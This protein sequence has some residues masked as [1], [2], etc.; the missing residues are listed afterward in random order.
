MEKMSNI[1]TFGNLQVQVVGGRTCKG[2]GEHV[3]IVEST[4]N[5][6]TERVSECLNCE[7]L[8]IKKEHEDFIERVNE[9][10]HVLFFEKYSFVPDDLKQSSF[11]SFDSESPSQKEAYDKCYWYARHFEDD[12]D[13]DSL[14][15]KG[16]YGIGKSHLS[17][18]VADM[19]KAQG[20]N[21]I[22]IDMPTLSKKIR[23]S[24]NGSGIT[25]DEIL[26]AIDKADLVI[27]DDMGAERVKKDEKGDSW[28]GDIMF[29]ALTSRQG[30][31]KVITTN[32]TSGELM[33][34][35]G[36]NGGRIVSRM[37]RGLKVIPVEG[38]DR[39][40]PKF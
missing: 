8:K 21:V 22:F 11:G 29:Q 4:R 3:N 9:M 10:Q 15:L 31:A 13:F 34:L 7:T 38:K 14:L 35:Y 19:V 25:E 24:Y 1:K 26:N 33:E 28:F 6:K 12:K 40:E 17:K 16:S 30:K 27:F 36:K 2:C 39:R 5:G 37:N 18:S 23:N 32:C 20:K